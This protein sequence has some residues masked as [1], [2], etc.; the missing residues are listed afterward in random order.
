MIT[1]MVNGYFA[2]KGRVASQDVTMDSKVETVTYTKFGK[3]IAVDEKGIQSQVEAIT[4]TNDPNDPTKA[5]MT[6]VPEIKGYK[7]DKT[8][9]TPSNP[10][11]DTRLFTRWLMQN[12]L[13]RQLTK[14]LVLSLLST[15]TIW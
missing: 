14:K 8:G 5:A 4:Y 11:E 10:G 1:P 12:L 7:A 2:D 6:L 3:I 13:N 9:V 15:V